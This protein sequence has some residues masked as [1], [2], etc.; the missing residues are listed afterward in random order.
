MKINLA[1]VMIWCQW[2]TTLAFGTFFIMLML[3]RYPGGEEIVKQMFNAETVPYFF[4]IPVTALNFLGM[5]ICTLGNSA[6]VMKNKTKTLGQLSM[7]E[8]H[9]KKLE[10]HGFDVKKFDEGIENLK[11]ELM[12]PKS[13]E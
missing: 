13:K 3:L 8:E 9:D 2:I 12:T 7:K 6:M 4:I 11:Q 5:L 1:V 10:S